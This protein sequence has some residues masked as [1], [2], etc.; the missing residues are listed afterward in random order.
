MKKISLLAIRCYQIF[1]S[2]VL[3][4]N[5]RFSPTCSVYTCEAI[6]KHGLLKGLFLA[7]RRL[8]KCHPFHPGGFDPIP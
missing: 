5:C 7:A 1:L 3:G 6:G 8:L 4:G 2:P